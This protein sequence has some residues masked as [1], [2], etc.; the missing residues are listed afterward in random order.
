MHLL[1]GWPVKAS[2][3][4]GSPAIFDFLELNNYFH[5]SQGKWPYTNGAT[6]HEGLF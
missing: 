6:I 2:R 5:D 1:T 4:C 3:F